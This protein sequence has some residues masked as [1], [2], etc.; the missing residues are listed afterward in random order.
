MIKTYE[1]LLIWQ[2]SMELVT[3]IYRVT[4][5]YPESE[6]FGL[7]SQLRRA[8]ISIPS[9]IAEG[10]GRNSSGDFKR[11]LNIAMGSLF[12]QQTE[13]RISLNLQFIDQDTFNHLYN[14]S[15]EI[16]R[17]MSAFIKKIN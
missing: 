1:D 2:Y 9:N 13:L 15:R 6:K 17:M 16:E 7:T 8:S 5:C 11:F 12:E 4:S 14:K 3:D 10:F